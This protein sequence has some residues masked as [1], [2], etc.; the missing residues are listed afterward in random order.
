MTCIVGYAEPDGAVSIAGDSAGMDD[1]YNVVLRADTKVF[2]RA[3]FLIGFTTS[4]RMGQILRYAWTPP[5]RYD[6]ISDEVYL[7]RDC[8]TSMRT[9]L[10]DGGFAKIEHTREEGGT[11]LLAFKGV[12]YCV[13]SDFQ[14]ARS[15]LPY[16]SVGC[17]FAYAMGV[18]YGLSPHMAHPDVPLGR[19]LRRALEAAAQFSGGVRAPFVCLR[20]AADGTLLSPPEGWSEP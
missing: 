10:K 15:Q 6:G 13:Y 7:Y 19:R 14:I 20:L 17:G 4:F 11:F 3:P 8:T 12:L 2:H 5:T 9:A 1:G 18:L 16:A